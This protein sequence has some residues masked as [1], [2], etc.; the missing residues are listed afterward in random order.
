MRLVYLA[1]PY[2]NVDIRQQLRNINNAR[3][4]ALLCAEARIAYFCPHLNSRLF[5]KYL[6]EVPKEYYMRNDIRILHACD[7]ILLLPQWITSQ[8]CELELLVAAEMNLPKF[9][10]LEDPLRLPH[11]LLTWANSS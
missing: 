5:D 4:T 1:G 8:G 2:T 11:D 9:Y 6:P 10:V 7:A 3:D